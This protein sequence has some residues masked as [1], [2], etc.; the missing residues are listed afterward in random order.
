MR[1]NSIAMIIIG[2]SVG[3]MRKSEKIAA[4]AYCVVIVMWTVPGLPKL[5]APSIAPALSGY[6]K[7]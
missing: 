3:P 4:A 2:A 1:L 5:L 6:G 7:G